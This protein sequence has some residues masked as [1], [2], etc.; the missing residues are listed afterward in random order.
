VRLLLRAS[1][2]PWHPSADSRTRSQRPL[3]HRTPGISCEAVPAS[4]RDGAGMRRHFVP[5]NGAA[6]SFVSFIPLFCGP[7]VNSVR[8]LHGVGARTRLLAS[9][10]NSAL[11]NGSPA[12]GRIIR[13][14]S[15]AGPGAAKR[16]RSGL[17]EFEPARTP[18]TVLLSHELV[19]GA[20]ERSS[21]AHELQTP[22]VTLTV[23]GRGDAPVLRR[24]A[25]VMGLAHQSAAN[26]EPG[27]AVFVRSAEHRG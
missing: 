22:L 19:A 18:W 20:H 17:G 16:I 1:D 24:R 23:R 12:Y 27:R 3:V 25:T 5:R 15:P 11:A 6:E 2:P 8:L 4:N 10:S 21:R 9:S 7:V 26:S 13:L 14:R